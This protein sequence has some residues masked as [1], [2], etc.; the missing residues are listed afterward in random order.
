MVDTWAATSAG[1]FALAENNLYTVEA[2]KDYASRLEP[3]GILSLTR[4]HLDPPDQLLR[5][6]SLA[7]AMM[8]ELSIAN[9]ERHLMLVRDVAD[10]QSGR[11]AATF[12][13]KRGEFDGDEIRPSRGRRGARR[14]HDP[15]HALTRPANDFTRLIGRRTRAGV[16]RSRTTSARPATTIPS[17]ST[18]RGC[19]AR[20]A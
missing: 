9:P 12:L 15:L 16:A 2:F 14:L 18:R 4:W 7:R 1:A 17:S 10:S 13:F 20:R 19:A 5:L 6:V 11:A 3:D 8:Q